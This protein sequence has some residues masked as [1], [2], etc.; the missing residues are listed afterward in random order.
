MTQLAGGVLLKKLKN[1]E[2][3]LKIFEFLWVGENVES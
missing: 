3:M 1:L 2:V